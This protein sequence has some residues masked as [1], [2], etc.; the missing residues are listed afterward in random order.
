VSLSLESLFWV[1][2][3]REERD[4][5]LDALPAYFLEMPCRPL[6]AIGLSG[7]V[8]KGFFNLSHFSLTFHS[9]TFPTAINSH[10]YWQLLHTV[11]H[12]TYTN[13]DND[14]D[15]YHYVF[16]LRDH[17]NYPYRILHRLQVCMC[18]C[19]RLYKFMYMCVSVYIC[20]YYIM[21]VCVL[22]LVFGRVDFP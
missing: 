22:I 3:R 6:A 20:I 1:W 12:H 17:A 19:V 18:A 4:L 9:P 7:L 14:P 5:S 11:M 10:S 16:F 21:R 15:L 13:M 8:P 2:L